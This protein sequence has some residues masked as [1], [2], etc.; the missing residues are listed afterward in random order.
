M[1]NPARTG[2]TVGMVECLAWNN[3]PGPAWTS[4][5]HAYAGSFPVRETIPTSIL[6]D[7]MTGKSTWNSTRSQGEYIVDN[8]PQ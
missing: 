4:S 5:P 7:I 8:V 6:S 1:G 3:C 2:A